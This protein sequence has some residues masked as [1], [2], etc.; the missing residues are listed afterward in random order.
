MGGVSLSDVYGRCVTVYEYSILVKLCTSTTVLLIVLSFFL[1]AYNFFISI[2]VIAI[3]L[4]FSE[5][6]HRELRVDRVVM[7]RHGRYYMVNFV[8]GNEIIRA[9]AN[10]TTASRIA[11]IIKVPIDFHQ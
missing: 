11:S 6:Y 1:I 7:V 2:I 8:C 5:L 3:I 4:S 10:L 9:R